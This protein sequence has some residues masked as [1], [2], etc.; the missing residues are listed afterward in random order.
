MA[1]SHANDDPN[2]APMH[3]DIDE[4]FSSLQIGAAAILGVVAIILGIVLGV[5]LANN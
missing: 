3:H 1:D 5:V 2:V 4:G